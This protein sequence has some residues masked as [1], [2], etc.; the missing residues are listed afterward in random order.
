MASRNARLYE[1]PAANSLF[2]AALGK[3]TG[4]VIGDRQIPT[5]T[6]GGMPGPVTSSFDLCGAVGAVGGAGCNLIKSPSARALCMAGV[7]AISGGLTKSTPRAGNIDPSGGSGSGSFL[8]ATC[9]KGTV[10]VGDTCVSP[11]DAFPGGDPFT[12]GAGGVGTMGA[13]G[14]PAV[15]P[16]QRQQVTLRCPKRYVLAVDD[17][18]YPKGFIPRSL[19]KWA[20]DPKPMVSAMD[21]KI[22]RRA[23]AVQKRIQKAQTA[24]APRPRRK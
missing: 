11:G 24:L 10:R 6:M 7:G 12:F 19:R 15:T 20:P 23:K 2:S 17:L 9:P 4:G 1:G 3:L 22:V 21:A 13:M 14:M 16:A 8:P 5:L 18:C